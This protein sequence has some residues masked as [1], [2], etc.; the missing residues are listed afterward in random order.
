MNYDSRAIYNS[1]P[2]SPPTAPFFFF[3]HAGETGA[4]L[5]GICDLII[6]PSPHLG[7]PS[8]F[9]SLSAP[10][11]LALSH[12]VTS[13]SL[14]PSFPIHLSSNLCLLRFSLYSVPHPL[15]AVNSAAECWQEERRRSDIIGGGGGGGG[16]RQ[17]ICNLKR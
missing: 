13:L 3:S 9:I 6:T 2:S 16:G 17:A 8:A 10:V 1:R 4:R 7:D 11:S 12:R 15:S 14:L 5:K